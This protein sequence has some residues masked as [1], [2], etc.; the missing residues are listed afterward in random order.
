MANT[1]PFVVSGTSLGLWWVREN[2]YLHAHLCCSS[3]SVITHGN[4]I[5]GEGLG[6]GLWTK[7]WWR[8][9]RILSFALTFNG[10]CIVF[11]QAAEI[12]KYPNFTTYIKPPS[13][14]PYQ[15]LMM[16]EDPVTTSGAALNLVS[17][18][19]SSLQTLAIRAAALTLAL[20][21]S[22]VRRWENEKGMKINCHPS[23]PHQW[24]K[25][26]LDNYLTVVTVNWTCLF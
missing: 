6:C 21:L 13:H 12:F 23:H 2:K 4:P 3:R 17:P 14:C 19:E 18:K 11:W 20:M 9:R 25:E 22:L 8:S 15:P 1:C 10:V 16:M 24:K 26:V 7:L 5:V